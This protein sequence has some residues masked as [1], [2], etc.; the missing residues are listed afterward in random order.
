MKAR[1]PNPA[2]LRDIGSLGEMTP[3]MVRATFPQWR[4]FEHL[5]SRWAVRGGIVSWDGPES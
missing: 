1:E 3:G 4:I 5:G 2:S